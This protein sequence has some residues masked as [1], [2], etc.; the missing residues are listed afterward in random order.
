MHHSVAPANNAWPT[1]GPTYYQ[2]QSLGTG[3][4]ISWE[5]SRKQMKQVLVRRNV[6]RG[7]WD[8][9]LDTPEDWSFEDVNE[10]GLHT[11][12]QTI[13]LHPKT[14]TPHWVV[15][16]AVD[17]FIKLKTKLTTVYQASA[18]I[19]RFVSEE[20]PEDNQLSYEYKQAQKRANKLQSDLQ[21]AC[22]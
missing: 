10:Q 2:M 19:D 13:M 5:E 21:S 1:T 22:N 15:S 16:P 11:G 8:Y 3:S 14:V 18:E 17:K 9:Y 6:P 4:A 20:W 7:L 12:I